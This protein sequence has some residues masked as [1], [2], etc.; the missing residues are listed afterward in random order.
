M[1][2]ESGSIWQAIRR[3]RH[4]ETTSPTKVKLKTKGTGRGRSAGGSRSLANA[5]NNQQRS[6][7]LFKRP[8]RIQTLE[9]QFTNANN[10]FKSWRNCGNSAR[11]A[12]KSATG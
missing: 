12:L 10:A 7:L 1:I 3:L 2:L 11:H 4:F 6:A 8:S 9:Q 5:S